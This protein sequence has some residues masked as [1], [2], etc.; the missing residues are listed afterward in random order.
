MAAFGELS[1]WHTTMNTEELL[2]KTVTG[3][4]SREELEEVYD[5]LIKGHKETY[6]LLL[7]IGRSGAVKYRKTVEN[8]LE[9]PDDPMLSRLALMILCQYWGLGN[10][11]KDAIERFIRKVEW[12]ED[13]DVRLMAVTCA[14]ELLEDD[15]HI[16]L[17]D[18]VY[19]IY[20]DPAE[21]QTMREVAYCALAIGAGAKISELPPASRHFSLIDDIDRNLIAKVES[22]LQAWR[23]KTGDD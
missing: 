10:E 17:L 14:G 8:F 21:G 3:E 20:S 5:A 2:K 22:R 13:E 1:G 9:H 7:I 6:R 16:D 23:E 15:A 12:D 18:E 11:Y 19:R 4:V